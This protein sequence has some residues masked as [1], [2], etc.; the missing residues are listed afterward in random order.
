MHGAHGSVW[1]AE[2]RIFN[3]AGAIT[4]RMLGPEPIDHR[5]ADRTRR[6]RAAAHDRAGPAAAPR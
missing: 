4:L 5:S 6:D 1:E 2:L 3:E